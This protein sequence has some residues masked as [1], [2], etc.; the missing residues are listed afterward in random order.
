MYVE[1][2]ANSPEVACEVLADV[3][4]EALIEMYGSIG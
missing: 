3:S 2:L 1:Q 4:T